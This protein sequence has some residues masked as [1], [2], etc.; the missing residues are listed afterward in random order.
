MSDLKVE[1]LRP[2]V[3]YQ[4][5]I[6]VTNTR[7]QIDE[8]I[9]INW[10]L[11]QFFTNCSLKSK[12]IWNVSVIILIVIP[13]IAALSKHNFSFETNLDRIL[14]LNASS[15][16][17]FLF[18][19]ILF[20]QWTFRESV[21]NQ[22]NQLWSNINLPANQRIER[23]LFRER[24]IC[25]IMTIAYISSGLLHKITSEEHQFVDWISTLKSVYSFVHFLAFAVFYCCLYFQFLIEMVILLTASFDHVNY[26]VELQVENGPTLNEIRSIRRLYSDIVQLTDYVAES[27]KIFVTLIYLNTAYRIVSISY[28]MFISEYTITTTYWKAL[29]FIIGPVLVLFMTFRII[30]VNISAYSSFDD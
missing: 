21:V 25:V 2:R 24:S 29:A 20:H 19:L 23:F 7:P 1:K 30:K 26:L 12:I 16:Y 4:H 9:K 14:T 6:F 8:K 18:Y 15:E 22:I 27:L 3:S 13:I 17:L 10:L 11:I 28:T 5:K